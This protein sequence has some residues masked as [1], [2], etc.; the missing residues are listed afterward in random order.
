M[1]RASPRGWFCADFLFNF[2]TRAEPFKSLRGVFYH[3][4]P[5]PVKGSPQ[6][7]EQNIFELRWRAT[8]KAGERGADTAAP[9]RRQATH[10]HVGFRGRA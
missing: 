3:T 8:T 4:I 9:S 7:F 6:V 2:P 1:A 10:R 5:R